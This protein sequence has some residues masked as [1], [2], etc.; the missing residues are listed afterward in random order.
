MAAS[1]KTLPMPTMP[2]V[3]WSVPIYQED[4]IPRWVSRLLKK[5]ITGEDGDTIK[6]CPNCIGLTNEGD[7]VLYR[8]ICPVDINEESGLKTIEAVWFVLPID[9]AEG[10]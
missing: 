6:P 1:D 7:L 9:W 5:S 3:K 2:D 4:S 10:D 8:R